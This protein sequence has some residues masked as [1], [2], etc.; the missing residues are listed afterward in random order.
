ME[1]RRTIKLKQDCPM[2][3][4]LAR[5]RKQHQLSQNDVCRILQLDT[6]HIGR[7]TYSKYELG[8]LNIPISLLIRLKKIYNCTYDEFFAGLEPEPKKEP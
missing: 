2:G 8:V 1:N 6:Y 7:S 3:N 5:L 4:N